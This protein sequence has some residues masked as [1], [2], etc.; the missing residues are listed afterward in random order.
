MNDDLFGEVKGKREE[1]RVFSVSEITKTVRGV[2]EDE[3]GTIWV[4]GEVSNYRKQASGHEYFVLK[5]ASA[6]LSC[7]RFARGG[8]RLK[9]V[10]LAEG[11][12]IQVRGVLTV[13]EARGQYQMNV[14]IVQAGG[15]GLLQA[16]FEA[17]KRQL[18]AEGLFEASRKRALPRFPKAMGIVTSATGAALRD[19]LS[20]LGRRAPWLRVVLFPARVQG[21]GAA[22]EVASGIEALNR[23]AKSGE[24][25]LDLI[26]VTRGGGSV[27]DL[28]AFNEDVLARAIAGSAL[29]VVSAV[30]HEIDFTIADFVADLRAPT[31]SAAAELIAPDGGEL[32][33]RIGELAMRLVRSLVSGL[34]EKRRGVEVLA[35]SGLFR[36]PEKR[37]AEASQRTD[38]AQESLERALGR[39]ME[40]G[41]QQVMGLQSRL[42]EYRPDQLL[43][44]RRQA[45]DTLEERFLRK[46]NDAWKARADQLGR[47]EEMLGL[48]APQATL[49]RGY[50]MTMGVGGKMVGSVEDVKEGMTLTTQFKDGRV[51]SRVEVGYL[52]QES[53]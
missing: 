48:L 53:D 13:Y 38:L 36:E 21:G 50:T 16:K 30:G 20:V 2:L 34:A 27:E 32:M 4:E 35:R 14:Q 1:P 45:F 28:W 51:E 31:P 11:M 39:G 18:Q 41:R 10:A 29:P 23:L 46:S 52:G 33:R 37:L 40:R 5:D 43:A 8:T 17:L 6:Q 7:V 22:E 9:S 44:L 12:Q 24:R 25:E 3:I 49:A 26:V 42:R 15:A 47:L 19:M